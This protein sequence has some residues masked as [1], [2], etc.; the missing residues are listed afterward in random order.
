M[1]AEHSTVRADMGPGLVML[2]GEGEDLWLSHGEGVRASIKISPENFPVNI[3][4]F[5]T[6]TLPAGT[7]FGEPNYHRGD[8]LYFVETGVGEATLDGVRHDIAQGSTV[9][10]GRMTRHAFRNRGPGELRLTW[11]NLPPGPERLL[12]RLGKPVAGPAPAAFTEEERAAAE[13]LADWYGGPR[14]LRGMAHSKG[15][16]L[17]I[18]PEGGASY[19]Q[20]E[21]T[22]GYVTVKLSPYNLP[23]NMF[24]FGIQ[25]V[26][27]GGLLPSH[28]H[29]RNEELKYVWDGA[30]QAT[31]NGE[32]VRAAPGT[33]VF[34]GRW[35]EHEFRADDA[36]PMTITWLIFPAG[37]ENVLTGIGR[38]RDPAD[39][40]PG[41]FDLP[42]NL[43]DM[44]DEAGF[45]PVT[46]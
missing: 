36:G 7:S 45:G 26:G 5:G 32:T 12:R 28:S 15:V 22:G 27:P 46:L 18:D 17:V 21:P 20:P 29:S 37:L 16:S 44:L 9:Y 1:P 33:T 8:V 25:Q 4:A 41:A 23:T 35:V 30:G 43:M 2:P 38:E 31:V 19:W 6:L 14:E 42:G 10:V 24:A 11:T 40:H 13:A 39:R 3:V 34:T